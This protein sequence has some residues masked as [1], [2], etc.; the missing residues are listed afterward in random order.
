[1]P[2][3]LQK[4]CVSSRR[5]TSNISEFGIIIIPSIPSIDPTNTCLHAEN[6][7]PWWSNRF[8]VAQISNINFIIWRWKNTRAA[9]NKGVLNGFPCRIAWSMHAGCCEIFGKRKNT[10]VFFAVYTYSVF[11]RF[12]KVESTI[13][14]RL[15][16]LNHWWSTQF[17]QESSTLALSAFD[18]TLK[19]TQF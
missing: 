19:F 14:Q 5:V 7:I 2:E 18:H 17:S 13:K 12:P 8:K 4:G 11:L 15:H 1:M 16:F 10:H 9:A 3:M 6:P